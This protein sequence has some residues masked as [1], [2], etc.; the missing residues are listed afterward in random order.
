MTGS[1]ATKAKTNPNHSWIKQLTSETKFMQASNSKPTKKFEPPI[2]QVRVRQ[3]GA[4]RGSAVSNSTPG[5]RDN[6]F[7]K[8]RDTREDRG[9]RQMKTS[10]PSQ[11][12]PSAR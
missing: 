3:R 2:F 8:S 7:S 6:V 10:R 4:G 12:V 9:L 11:T 1:K 5:K